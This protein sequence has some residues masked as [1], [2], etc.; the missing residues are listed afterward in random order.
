MTLNNICRLLARHKL[1]VLLLGIIFCITVF[2]LQTN[3]AYAETPDCGVPN[4]DA[5]QNFGG[6]VVTM[7]WE[8]SSGVIEGQADNTLAS[9]SS[10][11]QTTDSPD[12]FI[13][14]SENTGNF[15]GYHNSDGTAQNGYSSVYFNQENYGCPN[16]GDGWSVVLG[17]GYTSQNVNGTG[18]QSIG[19]PGEY[20]DDWYLRCGIDEGDLQ[21]FI[22]TGEGTPTGA[23]PGGIWSTQTIET[24]PSP[25]NPNVNGRTNYLKIVYKE[26]PPGSINGEI[27]DTN[28]NTI[29][30]PSSEAPSITVDSLT[31]QSADPTFS[32]NNLPYNNNH[33]VIDGSDTLPGGYTLLGS[34]WCNTP[35]CGSSLGSSTDG[36]NYTSG[37]AT[38]NIPVDSTVPVEMHWIYEKNSTVTGKCPITGQSLNPKITLP[39]EL[40]QDYPKVGGVSQGSEGQSGITTQK[41]A[42][43]YQEVPAGWKIITANDDVEYGNSGTTIGWTPNN[44]YQSS[45]VFTLNYT[46]YIDDYP[47]DPHSTT[48][49]YNQQFTQTRFYSSSSPDGYLCRGS[50]TTSEPDC[51]YL[52][53]KKGSGKNVSYTCAYSTD[54]GPNSDHECY[55][56]GTPYYN[57]HAGSPTTVTGSNTTYT[58]APVLSECYYRTFNLTVTNATVSFNGEEDN[59]TSITMSANVNASF[60]ITEPQI[61]E[62]VHNPCQVKGITN[63]YIVS[64]ITPTGQVVSYPAANTSTTFTYG[65]NANCSGTTVTAIPKTDNV[66]MP[67]LTFG[68]SIC[69][70]VDVKPIGTQM[71][72]QGNITSNNGLTSTAKSACSSPIGAEPYVRVFGGDVIAGT[73]SDS[74]ASC[75]IGGSMAGIDSFNQGGNGD[76]GAGTTTSAL[77]TGNIIGFA[78]GQDVLN[79]LNPPPLTFANYL[80]S[81]YGGNFSTSAA[82]CSSPDYYTQAKTIQSQGPTDYVGPCPTNIAAMTLGPNKQYNH[83][84][85]YSTSTVS[86][87]GPITYAIPSGT[88]V[89]LFP[90]FEIV[91][92][93]ANINI[94]KTVGNLAGEYV[95]ELDPTT[96]SGGTINDYGGGNVDTCPAADYATNSPQNTCSNDRLVIDGSFIANAINFYRTY[97]TLSAAANNSTPTNCSTTPQD[98]YDAEEFDYSPLNWLGPS[99]TQQPIVQAIT[100]L[101]PV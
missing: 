82:T 37:E 77:A 21:N 40:P 89:N 3:K 78:S 96:N 13:A 29:T 84:T 10:H 87:T 47:Y 22:V 23:I 6:M 12:N 72:Y 26:P 41:N 56:P 99:Y 18:G 44:G 54:K 19:G 49:T 100:S 42:Q 65:P 31:P 32:F 46:N 55:Y 43:Y 1:L 76:L 15:D 60:G 11:S 81:P 88:A 45:D 86:I 27:I 98:C 57:W 58:G 34:I 90:S 48:V 59:P 94:G 91:V 66:N 16:T 71:D 33:K 62:A 14:N 64:Y 79:L 7:Y 28:G 73:S 95:A 50:S 97:G 61:S 80:A 20:G 17:Y 92:K 8:N 85:C 63:S 24:N 51:Y 36:Q 70:E 4:S 9:V 101:P 38:Y 68:D 75:Y 2:G 5:S 39:Q 83:Y 74:I 30:E 93:G 67:P 52:A 53:T 25:T 69:L 35:S